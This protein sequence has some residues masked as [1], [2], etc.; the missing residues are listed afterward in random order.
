MMRTGALILTGARDPIEALNHE[1]VARFETLKAQY[2]AGRLPAG[3]YDREV[4]GLIWKMD[5]LIDF[6]N[7]APRQLN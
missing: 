3:E 2:T 5:A 7:S 6:V 1:L 4:K